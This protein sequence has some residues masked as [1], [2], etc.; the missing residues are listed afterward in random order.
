[1]A[2]NTE[3]ICSGSITSAIHTAQKPTTRNNHTWVWRQEAVTHPACRRAQR[4]RCDVYDSLRTRSTQDACR[5]LAAVP[6]EGQI[7]QYETIPNGV[8]T[9]A[10]ARD[11][12]GRIGGTDGEI[13]V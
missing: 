10:H 13:S 12:A 4:I 5:L 8:L 11:P 2:T 1:M 7:N 3:K 9:S 6:R